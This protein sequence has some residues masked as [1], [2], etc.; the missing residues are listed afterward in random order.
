MFRDGRRIRINGTPAV[1]TK[2][3]AEAAER[4]HIER[5]LSP[6]APV[7]KKEVPTFEEFVE[8]FMATVRAKNKPSEIESKEA[9]YDS[10]KTFL[11]KGR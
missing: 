5:V 2:A 7:T 3:A 9:I 6:A 10:I 8:P 1:D 4:A 11:G